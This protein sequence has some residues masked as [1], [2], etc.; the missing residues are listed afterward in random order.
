MARN[1]RFQLN[2]A[3]GGFVLQSMAASAVKKSAN[4]IASRAQ[5]NAAALTSKPPKIKVYTSVGVI[6]KGSRAIAVVR[7]DGNSRDVYIATKAISKAKD[8]GKVT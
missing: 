7:A 4:A 5:S 1:V 6:K 2:L 3:G 8:A